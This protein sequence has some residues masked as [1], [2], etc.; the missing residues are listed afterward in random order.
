MLHL[1]APDL[2]FLDP[3]SFGGLLPYALGFGFNFK[4]WRV[5]ESNL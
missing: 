2:F 5:I 4:L 1:Q 3:C